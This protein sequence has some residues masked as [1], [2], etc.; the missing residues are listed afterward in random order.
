MILLVED[1]ALLRGMLKRALEGL[2]HEIVT[3]SSGDEALQLLR[4]GLTPQLVFTDIVM[5]GQNDGLN[6]ARWIR[7]N[8]PEIA[9]L[10]Q[11]GFTEKSTDGFPVLLKPFSHA[12]LTDAIRPLLGAG[13][14]SKKEGV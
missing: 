4:D 12:D 14:S 6:V 8:R 5:P 10:L 3:A 7:S 13:C 2:G 9:V 1:H 11:T